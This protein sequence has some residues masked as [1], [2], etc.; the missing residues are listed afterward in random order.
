M[1]DGGARREPLTPHRITTTAL[2]LIDREGVEAFSMRAL[3]RELGVDPMA[4]YHHVPSKQ[5]LFDGIAAT[6]WDEIELPDTRDDW[7]ARLR[8]LA[9]EVRRVL[10]RHAGAL[11]IIATR[12]SL[13]AG[14]LRVLEDG[15]EA[16]E[17]SGLAPSE[18]LAVLST[19]TSWLVGQALA[20]VG[21]APDGAT[22]VSDDVVAHAFR[23]GG[24]E[25]SH[26]HLAAAAEQGL[27]DW[28]EVFELG[29]DVIVAGVRARAGRFSGSA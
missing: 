8:A 27:L 23:E 19:A 5:R 24:K 6:V 26:P 4:V 12:S 13:A 2:E 18:S 29:L 3:G 15:L 28:D 9:S 11:P 20:E 7:V 1:E 25:P 17:A 14:S 21:A 16:L 22:P 10:T